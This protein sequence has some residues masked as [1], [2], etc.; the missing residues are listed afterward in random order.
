[1]V[2]LRA[3]DSKPK[4][5]P[6]ADFKKKKKKV[7][8]EVKR[9][10]VTSVK[11]KSR[12]INM[13]VQNDITSIETVSDRGDLNQILKGC[14]HYSPSTRI[15]NLEELKRFV[16]SN[17]KSES[18]VA[19]IIP[20]LL[21]LLYDEDRDVRKAVLAAS[22]VIFKTFRSTAFSAVS[23]ISVTYICSGLTSIHKVMENITSTNFK[24]S[25]G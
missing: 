25:N 4:K 19:Y 22:I 21:E 9:S 24:N 23:S 20:S 7:G 2:S 16:T 15:S 12:K 14:H 3:K 6:V 13:P 18:Y 8:K 17:R 11:V 5:G 10:N 1:M